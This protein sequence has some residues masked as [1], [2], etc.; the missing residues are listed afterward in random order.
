VQGERQRQQRRA[1]KW[2]EKL[3]KRITNDDQVKEFKMA[4]GKT[5][6]GTFQGQSPESQ[7]K[8]MG[9]FMCPCYHMKGECWDEGC[10]YSK[11]HVLASEVKQKEKREYLD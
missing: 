3:A 6:Q 11:M 10:K 2:Q 4:K 7:V 8:W 5:W 1:K 9:A